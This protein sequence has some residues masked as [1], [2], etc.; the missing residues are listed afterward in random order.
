MYVFLLVCFCTEAPYLIEFENKCVAGKFSFRFAGFCCITNNYSVAARRQERAREQDLNR[1]TRWRRR[2]AHAKARG[3]GFILHRTLV[4]C[5][6]TLPGWIHIYG[7][8]TAGVRQVQRAG[9]AA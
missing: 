4:G 3:S 5:E 1:L 9:V 8:K 7:V 6:G 2:Q